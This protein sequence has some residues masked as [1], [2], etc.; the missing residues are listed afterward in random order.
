M[1]FLHLQKLVCKIRLGEAGTF[2][3]KS[4]IIQ[5]PTS[6][7]K[8]TSMSIA[9]RAAFSYR[10]TSMAVVVVASFRPLCREISDDIS[11]DFLSDS[12]VHVNALSDVLEIDDRLELLESFGES[13]SG[14]WNKKKAKNLISKHSADCKL[15]SQWVCVENA[16]EAIMPLHQFEAVQKL[17][18]LDSRSSPGE[19]VGIPFS[20]FV[21][22]KNCGRNII[23]K[24]NCSGKKEYYYYV[25]N[26][27]NEANTPC[28]LHRVSKM[29]LE[30]EVLRQIQ[31]RVHSIMRIYKSVPSL[32]LSYLQSLK[33][34]KVSEEIEA[35]TKK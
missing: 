20:G 33:N 5:M 21:R 26:G 24:Q 19:K 35:L 1:K 25:C 28:P 27:K 11:N 22:C 14:C 9:I 6:S 16:H 29:D 8:T 15:R 4:A 34:Q 2:W 32:D 13:I 12:N 17:L 3:E 7:G 18:L 31:V 10:R 30:N 23:Q